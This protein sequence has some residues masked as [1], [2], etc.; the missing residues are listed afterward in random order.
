MYQVC[1]ISFICERNWSKNNGA[2]WLVTF[3]K[4]MVGLKKILAISWVFF[5]ANLMCNFNPYKN[6]L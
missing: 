6:T 2:E 1:S 5:V 4:G 3:L